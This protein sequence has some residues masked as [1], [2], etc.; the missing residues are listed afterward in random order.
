[1]PAPPQDLIRSTLSVIFIGGLIAA[2]LWVMRPF[3]PATMWAMTLVIATWPLMLRIERA[4]F[5][6]RSLAVIVMTVALL[7]TVIVPLW[8]AISTIVDYSDQIGE[9]V[10]NLLSL[11]IPP[12]PAWLSSVPLVGVGVA[13]TWEAAAAMS[14]HEL[15]P[16]LM[17]YAGAATQ[18]FAGMIGGLGATFLQFLLTVAIAAIMY[19]HGEN[20]VAMTLRFA[21]R[22]GGLRGAEAVRLAGQAIR[23][24]ALGVVVTAL[25]QS[26]LGGI[27]LAVAGVPLA[28]MLT[29]LMFMLCLAQVGPT[30]VMVP[31][32]VWLY[33]EN[34]TTQGT[35]LVCFAIPVM[36][37]DNVLRPVLIRRGADLPLLLVFAGVIGGLIAYGL[38]GIFLGPT[39][40]AVAYALTNAWTEEEG[41]GERAVRTRS[42]AAPAGPGAD[43]RLGDRETPANHTAGK[44]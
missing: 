12:P 34:M 18:W 44:L 4:L 29:A 43:G 2:S 1:M 36:M 7:L 5:G 13:H 22:L 21:H 27:G 35:I 10:R 17:P 37:L 42:F 15:A 6:R 32:V 25:V 38:L 40:L 20:G 3:L 19:A 9:L 14:A 16:K 28:S 33:Y 31:A 41:Q 11:R 39:V 24:V 23:G 30:P 26:V 8:L